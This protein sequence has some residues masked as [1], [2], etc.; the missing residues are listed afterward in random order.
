MSNPT[1]SDITYVI[2]VRD[3]DESN[4]FTVV[5]DANVEVIDID[6]GYAD[7]NEEFEFLSWASNLLTQYDAIEEDKYDDAR[8][9][10]ANMIL[11]QASEFGHDFKELP[12]VRKAV[13][14]YES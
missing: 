6:L 3:P 13:A 5:G 4:E 9:L 10:L 8:D 7:L 1:E 14:E 12:D 11:D 2:C